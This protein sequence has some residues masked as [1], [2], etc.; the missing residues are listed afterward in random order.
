MRRVVQQMRL[1]SQVLL[2][3]CMLLVFGMMAH[4]GAGW[5]VASKMRL[6]VVEVRRSHPPYAAFCKRNPGQCDMTGK[7]VIQLNRKL[8]HSISEVNAAVNKAVRCLLADKLLHGEEEY[9]AYPVAG[10]GDCEDIALEKRRRLAALGLPR[11]SMTIAIVQIRKTMASHAVLLIET[12]TG[13]W[14]L[15][16]LTNKISA[17]SEVPYNYEA[18]ERVDGTWERYDQTLWVYD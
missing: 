1:S 17:W 10:R 12:T 16:N 9:W 15:D 11:A 8:K 6:P 18:R 2:T 5:G 3:S 4:A 7:A 14:V 13:T